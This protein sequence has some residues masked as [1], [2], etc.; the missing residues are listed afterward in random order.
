MADMCVRLDY[1]YEHRVH[2]A[3]VMLVTNQPASLPNYLHKPAGKYGLDGSPITCGF[4]GVAADYIWDDGTGEELMQSV[5]LSIER[6]EEEPILAT[7]A[8]L[9][10]CDSDYVF[11]QHELTQAFD[12]IGVG[13][14]RERFTL[15]R[16][17]RKP[18]RFLNLFMRLCEKMGDRYACRVPNPR[19]LR[20]IFRHP[21]P[22]PGLQLTICNIPVWGPGYMKHQT[23]I[24]GAGKSWIAQM[25]TGPGLRLLFSTFFCPHVDPVNRFTE[26]TDITSCDDCCLQFQIADA[27]FPETAFFMRHVRGNLRQSVFNQ[28]RPLLE[29]AF[30]KANHDWVKRHLI[31]C[32]HT[33][34]KGKII[35]YSEGRTVDA[36]GFPRGQIRS[37]YKKQARFAR[38]TDSV[39]LQRLRCIVAAEAG[40][41]DELLL[42]TTISMPH[43]VK[44]EKEFV[45]F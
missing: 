13:P 33:D 27:G 40:V 22:L 34:H 43:L 41:L 45:C 12:E 29:Q 31:S 36:R 28:L 25:K 19:S 26:G 44:T 24:E 15:I 7:P 14:L 11:N 4:E 23:S 38:Q 5:G 30:F 42:S 18:R 10:E 17:I 9:A 16:S 37:C 35:P 21:A 3:T 8:V 1:R 6:V 39:L 20:D 2:E 32:S